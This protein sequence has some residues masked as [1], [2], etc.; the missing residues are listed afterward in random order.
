MCNFPWHCSLTYSWCYKNVN[1]WNTINIWRN[2][3]RKWAY[4]EENMTMEGLFSDINGIALHYFMLKGFPSNLLL[5]LCCSLPNL[6]EILYVDSDI[7]CSADNMHLLKEN[8]LIYSKS[9]TPFDY[10]EKLKSVPIIIMVI[11]R[12]LFAFGLI[13]R[14]FPCYTMSYQNH[15]IFQA[16]RLHE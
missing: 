1:L 3:K 12:H 2:I 5:W 10:L 15:F 8:A 4:L 14:Q 13:I 9:S 6:M 11:I 7:I 16:I